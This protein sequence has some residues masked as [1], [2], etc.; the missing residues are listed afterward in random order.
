M[1]LPALP[2]WTS[3]ASFESSVGFKDNL[4]LSAENE[5]RSSFVRG[6]MEFLLMRVPTGPLELSLFGQADGTRFF[7]GET[8]KDER[9]VWLHTEAAYRAGPAWKFT[10]PV[11]AYYDAGVFDQSATDAE[12]IV[13]E[14]KVR[15]LM[16]G[17]AVRW[18][19]LPTW[20]VEAQMTGE[21]KRYDDGANDGDVGGEDVRLGWSPGKR[22]E[23]RLKG[24]RRWR[25]FES[26]SLFNA[27]GRE[28]IGT[29]LKVDER[30][31]ELRAEVGWDRAGRWRTTTR[32]GVLHYR[33]N[34]SGYFN[35]RDLRASQELE[36]KNGDWLVRL[37]AAINRIEFGVQTVGLGLAPPARV[38]DEYLA[39]LRV[40]RRWSAR[41]TVF[42]DYRW[43]RSRCN[44][45]IAS[46][47]VNEC[48]LGVRWS[49]ER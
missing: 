7:T 20:W 12:R 4:V 13:A 38:K 32:A 8:V 9:K 45:A 6:G 33:D 21:R 41:T 42:G 11:T 3:V 46:Y 34:G 28:L 22:L 30:E 10:L 16:V 17:P 25:A 5:E 14:L 39:A 19:F 29:E 35:Y 31:L 37:E 43:E 36:W 24:A 18:A 26:R 1:E 48:L 2:T 27:A 49:W 23:L 44:D 15:G 40:E 47:R